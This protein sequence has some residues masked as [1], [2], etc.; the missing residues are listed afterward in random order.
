MDLVLQ[1]ADEYV[2]DSVWARLVP[3]PDNALTVLNTAVT[4]GTFAAAPVATA[5]PGLTK[6]AVPLTAPLVSAWPRDYVPRQLA[7]LT[8]ITL[9][10]I[11]ILYFLFAWLSYAFIFDHDMMKHPRFLKNQVK[12]EIICSLKAFPGMTALTLPW[13]QAEV[14][15][16]SKLYEKVDEYG[17][18]WF[19]LSPLVY[20]NAYKTDVILTNTLLA[21]FSSSLTSEFT[22]FI[23]DCITHWST[24]PSISPITSG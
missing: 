3:A 4:N 1:L 2:L 13:F 16:Y 23:G 19:F 9:I 7:S 18:T 22:L 17:W 10:G 20:V 6:A 8:V 15:G 5:W 14:M 24:R 12:L 11:H 21:A